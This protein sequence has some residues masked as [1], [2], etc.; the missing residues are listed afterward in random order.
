MLNIA[1][2]SFLVFYLISRT[3]VAYHFRDPQTNILLK[4]L[5]T[6]IFPYPNMKTFFQQSVKK[7]VW[8]TLLRPSGKIFLKRLH[9]LSIIKIKMEGSIPNNSFHSP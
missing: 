6:S 2:V 1:R 9:N 4:L 8:I 3:N 7:T 5:Y